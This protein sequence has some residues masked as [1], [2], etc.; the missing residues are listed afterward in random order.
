MCGLSFPDLLD[1]MFDEGMMTGNQ[2]L[3]LNG[4]I[5]IDTGKFPRGPFQ[6]YME[7][8]TSNQFKWIIYLQQAK[9]K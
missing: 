5:M 1:F 2:Q 7:I 9:G 3:I 6:Y 4:S 8:F